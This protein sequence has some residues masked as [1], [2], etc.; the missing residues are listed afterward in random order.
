[1]SKAIQEYRVN[2]EIQDNKESKEN[3][4]SKGYKVDK[5]MLFLKEKREIKVKMVK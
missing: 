2:K 5:V 1:V 3:K 4:E